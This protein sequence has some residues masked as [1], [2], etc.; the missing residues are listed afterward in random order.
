M[1]NEDLES[2]LPKKDNREVNLLVFGDGERICFF[3]KESYAMGDFV[4]TKVFGNDT[5]YVIDFIPEIK[6]KE[7]NYYARRLDVKC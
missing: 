7:R 6:S 3:S 4:C 2:R 1:Q 5:V